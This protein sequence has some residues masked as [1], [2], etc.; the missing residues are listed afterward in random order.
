MER[1]NLMERVFEFQTRKLQS[2][3]DTEELWVEGYAAKFSAPTVL[4]ELEGQEY[5]EQISPNAFDN[6]NMKDVIF[7][8][9]HT[10]K[11]IARTKNDT[12]QLSIDTTGLFI[13]AK[14][15]GTE[16]GRKLYDEISK[17]YIDKMSFQFTIE[18]ES[19]DRTGREWTILSL[20]RL[21]DVSAV[22]IPAYDNTSIEARKSAIAT[23]EQ[24]VAN[25]KSEKRKRILGLLLNE[26]RIN[27]GIE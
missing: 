4:F 24:K 8:Y 13:R 6:C 9:N 27:N 17:G 21:F 12:L 26:G 16:E 23:I 18:E 19:F 11:V 1:T 15:N 2:E 10:G 25:V 14:L 3:M 5:R 22:D 7:N 20:K